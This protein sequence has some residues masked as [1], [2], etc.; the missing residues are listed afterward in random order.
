MIASPERSDYF[1]I[2]YNHNEMG[3]VY[4]AIYAMDKEHITLKGEGEIDLNGLSFY[5]MDKPTNVTSVGPEITSA[6]MV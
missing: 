3:D 5:H 1:P 6:L 4:S 2:G